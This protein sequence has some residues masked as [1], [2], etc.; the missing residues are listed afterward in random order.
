[1]DTPIFDKL[2]SA[3]RPEAVGDDDKSHES[4]VFGLDETEPGIGIASRVGLPEFTPATK[5]DLARLRAELKQELA[6]FKAEIRR[7]LEEFKARLTYR[8]YAVSV[9][10]TA[11][12]VAGFV[13]LFRLLP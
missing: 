5:A 11:L 3:N 10:Q 8:M 7:E 9:A 13:F 6:E 1:M 4:I 2:A 12:V